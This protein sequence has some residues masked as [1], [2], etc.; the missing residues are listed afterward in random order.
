MKQDTNYVSHPCADGNPE[1]TK[2]LFPRLP[3]KL[4]LGV[5]ELFWPGNTETTERDG[6]T[7]H[8]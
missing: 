7:I 5:F 1:Q 3:G 8:M 2:Q 4:C 6:N